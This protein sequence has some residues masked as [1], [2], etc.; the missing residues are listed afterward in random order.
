[1]KTL[2]DAIVD[3]LLK[4]MGEQNLTQY[5]LASLSGVPFSTIKSIMQKRTKSIDLKTLISIS[6]G[7][8]ISVAEF[9]DDKSFLSE[10]LELY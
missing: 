4:Y 10:N 2:S 1:M 3:R 8:G 7:L 5:K 6:N 9:L